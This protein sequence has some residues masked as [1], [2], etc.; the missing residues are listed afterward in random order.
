ML[1]VLVYVALEEQII[2]LESG[3]MTIDII[4]AQERAKKAQEK[5]MSGLN[6]DKIDK[7]QGEIQ[8]QQ[9]DLE[10][11]NMMLT[12]NGI[13]DYDDDD[14]LQELDELDLNEFEGKRQ[15]AIYSWCNIVLEQGD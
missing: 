6:V 1:R 5:L 2:G 11:I 14:L 9:G 13:N 8:D 4:A 10:E 15:G 3:A 12:E 7:L